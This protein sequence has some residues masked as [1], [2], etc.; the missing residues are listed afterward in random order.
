[1]AF[2]T[3]DRNGVFKPQRV[4]VGRTQSGIP[5]F[6]TGNTLCWHLEECQYEAFSKDQAQARAHAERLGFTWDDGSA[7]SDKQ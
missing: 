5:G 1:M 3:Y 2:G 6:F 4:H 7:T